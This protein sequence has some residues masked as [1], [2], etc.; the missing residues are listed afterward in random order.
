MRMSAGLKIC[1]LLIVVILGGGVLWDPYTFYADASD[2]L[3]RAPWW[4]LTLGLTNLALLAVVAWAFWTGS[5]RRAFVYLA[6]ETLYHLSLGIALVVRDG[7]E[8]FIVG[9]GAT[10]SVT[11]FLF[12]VLLRVV[13]LLAVF[14]EFTRTVH[15]QLQAHGSRGDFISSTPRSA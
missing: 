13:L 14:I 6:V 4:Q 10:E 5:L 12:L 7:I 15:R 3:I 2:V 11:V 9:I 8:R 1:G